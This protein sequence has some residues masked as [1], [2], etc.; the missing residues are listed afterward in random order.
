MSK[1]IS[2]L[3]AAT[4]ANTTDLF[5]K[6]DQGGAPS[7]G[8]TLAQIITNL[9]THLASLTLVSG[10]N[11]LSADGSVSLGSNTF[12]LNAD[13]TSPLTVITPTAGTSYTLDLTKPAGTIT[14][15]SQL[16]FTA[17]SNRSANGVRSIMVRVASNGGGARALTFNASWIFLGP[18]VPTT[19]AASKV[20][21]LSL[22]CFG[23]AETDVVAAWAVS[24]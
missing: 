21:I 24:P 5:E 11:V 7:Q 8:V 15:A 6:S 18:G 1:K 3:P 17:T 2:Q 19:I 12:I 16:D 14:T 22:T 9:Q 23:S 10:L 4:Q 13:G 20:G